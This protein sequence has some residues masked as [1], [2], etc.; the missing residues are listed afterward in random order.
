MYLK[1]I[2]KIICELAGRKAS[3]VRLPYAVL[4][5]VAWMIELWS[6][7]TGYEPLTTVDGIKMVRKTM[8]F[9]SDK[10]RTIL[11]YHS[12]PAR[13]ATQDAIHW[14]LNNGYSAINR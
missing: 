11:R 13:E 3:Q 6:E 7:H 2:L 14:F 9:F 5:P 1:N 4:L 12:R 10:A 8:F